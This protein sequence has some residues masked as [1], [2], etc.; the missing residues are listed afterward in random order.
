MVDKLQ[1]GKA[2]KVT[3]ANAL[4]AWGS[5]APQQLELLEN[6]QRTE[7]SF[8]VTVPGFQPPHHCGKTF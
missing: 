2:T 5:H 1:D 3:G 7:K 4:A 8:A 6:I